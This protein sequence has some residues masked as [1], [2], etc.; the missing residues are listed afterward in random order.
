MTANEF[1]KWL[2]S[3]KVCEVPDRGGLQNVYIIWDGEIQ[4]LIENNGEYWE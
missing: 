4:A 3:H 2:Q 1:I